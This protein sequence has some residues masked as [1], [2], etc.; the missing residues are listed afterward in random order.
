MS[1]LDSAAAVPVGDEAASVEGMPEGV[2]FETGAETAAGVVFAVSMAGVSV[3]MGAGLASERGSGWGDALRGGLT[4]WRSGGAM[5]GVG[6]LGSTSGATT[7]TE[8]TWGGTR[9]DGLTCTF[10]NAAITMPCPAM[11]IAKIT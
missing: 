1:G 5:A 11:V 8:S 7:D 9:L 4:G 6:G 10:I 3:A 2:D